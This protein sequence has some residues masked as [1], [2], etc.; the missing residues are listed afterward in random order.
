LAWELNFGYPIYTSKID[1]RILAAD[2]LLPTSSYEPICSKLARRIGRTAAA[3]DLHWE[4]GPRGR[5]VGSTRAQKAEA[6]SGRRPPAMTGDLLGCLLQSLYSVR[7][8]GTAVRGT[9]YGSTAAGPA[10]AATPAVALGQAP[11]GR[12][13]GSPLARGTRCLTAR[14]CLRSPPPPPCRT[15]GSWALDTLL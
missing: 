9:A 7:C 5:S 1:R 15:P 10:A 14:R 13:E 2:Q 6:G 11:G 8:T 4:P 3:V 12:E